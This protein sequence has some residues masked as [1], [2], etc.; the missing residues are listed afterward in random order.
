MASV[1]LAATPATLKSSGEWV[2]VTWSG[3]ISP[4]SQD[5]V[6][7]FPANGTTVDVKKHAPIKY[8]VVDHTNSK[9]A[10]LTSTCMQCNT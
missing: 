6:A 10:I 5:M 9:M 2:M 7:L 1:L 4:T 3:V 8:K